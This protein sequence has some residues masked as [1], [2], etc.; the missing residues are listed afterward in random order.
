M[1]KTVTKKEVA[2]ALN[3]D[4]DRTGPVLRFPTFCLDAQYVPRH[5]STHTADV[6][7]RR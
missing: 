5:K 2:L 7:I 3:P 6:F 1:G 4:F